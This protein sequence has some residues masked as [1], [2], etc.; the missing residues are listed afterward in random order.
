V[1]PEKAG[2]AE[3]KAPT[4]RGLPNLVRTASPPAAPRQP[5][6][7][8]S[9]PI[10]QG[11]IQRMKPC[12]VASAG[13]ALSRVGSRVAATRNLGALYGAR[14][15]APGN[16]PVRQKWKNQPRDVDEVEDLIG[17][18]AAGICGGGAVR[19]RSRPVRCG[20]GGGVWGGSL[21][22]RR[23]RGPRSSLAKEGLPSVK[24]ET[25]FYP[26]KHGFSEPCRRA[27]FPLHCARIAQLLESV[28]WTWYSPW[29]NL[30]PIGK[31]GSHRAFPSIGFK[32]NPRRLPA[33]VTDCQGAIF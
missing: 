6:R 2:A 5:P 11:N 8:N 19:W 15:G 17:G 18:D 26:R 3:A 30:R 7:A 32:S 16:K 24:G 25:S 20:G 14:G 13:C 10:K 22:R 1:L 4:N 33:N 28:A 23:M 21:T 29:I 9:S 31:G 12:H 27:I